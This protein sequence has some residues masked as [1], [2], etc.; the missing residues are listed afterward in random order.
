DDPDNYI[1]FN[2]KLVKVND[3]LD[4]YA[5]NLN[6]IRKLQNDLIFEVDDGKR[7]E[8]NTKLN[9][10][11]SFNDNLENQLKL[12]IKELRDL[13]VGDFIKVNQTENIKS[14]FMDLINKYRKNEMSYSEKV[15][16]DISKQYKIIK[17][18][19]T[20]QEIYNYVNNADV[21]EQGQQQVFKDFLINSTRKEESKNISRNVESRHE[22]I[23]KIEKKMN[24]LTKLF[25]EMENLIVE[26][27]DLINEIDNNVEKAQL[28]IGGANRDLEKAV[29]HG[30]KSRK[31]KRWCIFILVIVILL[32]I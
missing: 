6:I 2:K 4:L 12:N 27:D 3:K 30:R 24:E 26:Q 14:K 15:K 31:W 8:A 23:I 16:D 20:Q 21:Q 22:E 10:I 32:I 18:D 25:S 9:E 7:H 29:T 11:I 1:G 19:A 28:N 17:P 5:K 13:S